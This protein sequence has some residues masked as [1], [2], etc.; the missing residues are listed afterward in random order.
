LS[1][2]PGAELVKGPFQA[3]FGAGGRHRR[4]RIKKS[5]HRRVVVGDLLGHH[6]RQLLTDKP[7]NDDTIAVSLYKSHQLYPSNGSNHPRVKQ[8]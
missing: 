8:R 7:S 3:E 6:R 5:N 1:R 2:G 4:R